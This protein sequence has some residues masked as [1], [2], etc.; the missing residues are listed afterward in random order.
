M[1][2]QGS[3]SNRV[4]VT[5]VEK[6]PWRCI[7]SLR[8]IWRTGRQSLGTGWLVSPRVVLTAGQCVYLAGEGGWASEIEV[9]PGLDGAARPFGSAISRELRSVPGWIENE[10][11]DDDYGAILLPPDRSYGEELGWF[12]YTIRGDDYLRGITLNLSGYLAADGRGEEEAT[13]WYHTGAVKEVRT[14][15]LTY[16]IAAGIG[17]RGAPVWE[18][19]RDGQRYGVAIHTGESGGISRGTRIT[20]EVFDNILLWTGQAPR[21]RDAVPPEQGSISGRVV[22]AR[23]VPV[24]GAAVAVSGGSQPHRD[25]AAITTADG[26]FRLGGLP[27]G[28]YQLTAHAD[29]SVKSADVVVSAGT[30]ARVEIQLDA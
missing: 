8:V 14:R 12:G 13:Q 18:T 25:I 11:P 6:Y 24:V 4:R 9:I 26:T 27:P 19:A 7:C 16:E 15:Q 10:D 30:P 17:Q 5:N 29:S 21:K 23:G 22:N 3:I 2:E 20:S 28:S 1:P